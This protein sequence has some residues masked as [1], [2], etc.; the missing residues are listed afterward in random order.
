MFPDAAMELVMRGIKV[1]NIMCIWG[2]TRK[3]GDI[4]EIAL[5]TSMRERTVMR[6]YPFQL[7][8]TKSQHQFRSDQMDK[9]VNI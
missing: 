6:V 7:L 2:K 1:S 4:V 8:I 9:H 3:Y 5:E